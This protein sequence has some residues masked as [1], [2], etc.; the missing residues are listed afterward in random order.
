MSDP[1]L[2]EVPMNLAEVVMNCTYATGIDVASMPDKHRCHTFKLGEMG[3]P[4]SFGRQQQPQLFARLVK[5]E[6]LRSCISRSHVELIWEAP[7]L[8]LKKLTPN[9]LLIN[10]K[11]A[12]PAVVPLSQGAQLGFCP[13]ANAEG[14]GSGAPAPFLIFTVLMRDAATVAAI[15]PTALPTR[16][17]L[18]VPEHVVKEMQ[19]RHQQQQQ[20]QQQQHQV[21]QQQ[22][23]HHQLQQQAPPA[24]AHPQQPRV[25][26][27]CSMALEPNGR[28]RNL[29]PMSHES[30]MIAIPPDGRLIV[31]RQCQQGFFEGILGTD[32]VFLTFISRQHFELVASPSELS[33]FDVTNHSANPLVVN[34]QQIEKGQCLRARLPGGIDFIS[35][36]ISAA[37]PQVFFRLRLVEASQAS[38]ALQSS[39]AA[40]LQPSITANGSSREAPFWL[41]LGGTACKDEFLPTASSRRFMGTE[42][43]L[44]IGRTHQ[45]P[46]LHEALKEGVLQFLSREHFKIEPA[47]QSGQFQFVPLGANPMWRIRSGVRADATKGQPSLLEPGDR[48]LLFTGASDRTPDGPGSQGSL[49]FLFGDPWMPQA[50]G[51]TDLL[52]AIGRL[53]AHLDQPDRFSVPTPDRFSITAT[54][55]ME[56]KPELGTGYFNADGTPVVPASY[57]AIRQV[58]PTMAASQ[59]PPTMLPAYNS[60]LRPPVN[61]S[62]FTDEDELSGAQ[63]FDVGS[64]D[65]EGGQRS[66][67][68][69]SASG[70]SYH[71]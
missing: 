71:R 10:G 23:Q 26:L 14:G 56:S 21:L 66:S 30:R 37:G 36:G 20:Q 60:T 18:P 28:E 44:N 3:P 43:G 13:A 63:K 49:F 16:P 62:A 34:G 52:S 45:G 15:G 32:S 9:T 39:Q 55:V 69:F 12:P 61:A 2:H 6:A 41:E 48:I 4:W 57:Q 27:A 8:L 7:K 19:L 25:V 53:E 38:Q 58:P 42:A 59:A 22:Q 40:A 65:F 11:V 54:P 70:F 31:G 5:D 1:G 50:Q 47:T 33:A 29:E 51:A 64:L 24:V 35:K 46:L 67:D 17:D 68:A